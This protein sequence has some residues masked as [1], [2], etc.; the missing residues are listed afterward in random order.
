MNIPSSN[1]I[2]TTKYEDFKGVDFT[3]QVVE[4]NRFPYAKNFIITDMVEKR[5]GWEVLK[6][7]TDEIFGLFNTLIDGVEYYLVHTGDKLYSITDFSLDPTLLISELNEGKSTGFYGGDKYY[8]LTGKE[9][10]QFDG[11]T[12]KIISGSSNPING[13]AYVPLYSS[14]GVQFRSNSAIPDGGHTYASI[15]GTQ[16][17]GTLANETANILTKHKKI[18]YAEFL[19]Y[20]TNSTTNFRALYILPDDAVNHSPTYLMFELDGEEVFFDYGYVEDFTASQIANADTSPD[21]TIKSL[22][23]KTLYNESFYDVSVNPQIG[24]LYGKPFTVFYV[25][26]SST[27]SDIKPY[28]STI[29]SYI[30]YGNGVYYFFT[31][32]SNRPNMDWQSTLNDPTYIET[33]NYMIYGNE[34]EILG[35][36]QY[37]QYLAVFKKGNRNTNIYVRYAREIESLGVTFPVEVGVG[38]ALGGISRHTISNLE[39]ETLYLTNEGIYALTSLSTTNQK[40]TRNRSY[41]IDNALLKET[42]LSNAVATTWDNKYVLAINGKMYILDGSRQKSYVEGFTNDYVYECLFWDGIPATSLLSAGST[43]YFGT[44]DG[45]VCRFTDGYKDNN[46]DIDT[47][48]C[49]KLD[50]DGDFMTLKKLKK[51]GSGL[52]MQPYARSSFDV[53]FRYDTY[54]EVSIRTVYGDIFDFDNIDFDRFTFECVDNPRVMPFLKKSKKYKS[55][56]IIIRSNNQEPLGLM[57]IIK[58]FEFN[59]FVKR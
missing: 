51:K 40:V 23:Q 56:Q 43:L 57:G 18:K 20:N 24:D 6:T 28:E 29:S 52:L 42:T 14:G 41:F 15:T 3:S 36:G 11:T 33:D 7:F 25:S 39:G 50:D 9:Y 37:G 10:L 48:I 8:I 30:Q 16:Y 46:E 13:F 21:F 49:T 19:S 38:G 26:T 2:Y 1:P 12:I 45:K 5:N 58:R 55:L 54:E 22:D 47:V 4:R 44:S 32:N 35:Y 31:G 17:I 59:N 34:D 27:F 53:S